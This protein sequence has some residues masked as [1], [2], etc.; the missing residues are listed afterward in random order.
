M[1]KGGIAVLCIRTA[2][3]LIPLGST[4]FYSESLDK[5]AIAQ[6]EAEAVEIFKG[7]LLE[8]GKVKSVY[9]I[10]KGDSVLHKGGVLL[11]VTHEGKS[12]VA[13]SNLVFGSS[14]G[15]DTTRP[16]KVGWYDNHSG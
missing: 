7:L 15:V 14:T 2:L 16:V 8:P 13:Y 4:L 6:S 1:C 5:Y 9:T 3:M 10:N 12:F 11:Y